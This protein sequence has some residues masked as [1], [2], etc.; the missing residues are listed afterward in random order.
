[1]TAGKDSP[2]KPLVGPVPS[3]GGPQEPD[4]GSGDPA[5]TGPRRLGGALLARKNRTPGQGT[6]PTRG[7]VD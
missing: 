2:R 7:P 4:A 6:R 1:M 3:Q 5:Y